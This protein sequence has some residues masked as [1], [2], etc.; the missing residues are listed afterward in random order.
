MYYSPKSAWE[1][2]EHAA[3]WCFGCITEDSDCLCHH[4]SSLCLRWKMTVR[5]HSEVFQEP[6]RCYQH[7]HWSPGTWSGHPQVQPSQ[8]LSRVHPKR[9]PAALHTI[10]KPSPCGQCPLPPHCP[11][12][13]FSN[14]SHCT[15]GHDHWNLMGDIMT[16]D[17][18]CRSHFSC[19]HQIKGK[20]S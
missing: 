13:C 19:P 18:V 7:W 6:E 5:S 2:K 8:L 3:P 1:L 17:S 20:I 16:L 10:W 12:R 15:D 4:L 11:A 9:C 14:V